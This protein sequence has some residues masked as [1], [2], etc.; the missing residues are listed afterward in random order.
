MGEGTVPVANPSYLV[1]LAFFVFLRLTALL[2]TD[3]DVVKS[4][5]GLRKLKLVA[6]NLSQMLTNCVIW[7]NRL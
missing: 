3:S 7:D 5:R 2:R 4:C 1:Q 6:Q